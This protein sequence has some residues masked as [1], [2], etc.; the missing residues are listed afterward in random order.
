[1]LARANRLTSG[2]G[3]AATIRHG[4]RA[5]RP[6]MVVHLAPAD[7]PDQG[8]DHAPEPR[9]GLV[10][11]K[12]VGDAVSRNRVKR[13]LRHLVRERLHTLPEGAVLVIRALPSAETASY[14]ALGRDLDGALHRLLGAG[15]A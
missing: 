8:G 5:G 10:V 3:F 4:Q 13:R 6:T 1:M 14:A 12:A 15:R 11:G 9:V 7:R 2:R